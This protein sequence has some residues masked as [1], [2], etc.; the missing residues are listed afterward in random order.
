MNKWMK[1]TA[2]AVIGVLVLSGGVWL[3]GSETILDGVLTR[4]FWYMVGGIWLIL[5]GAKIIGVFH[6]TG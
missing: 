2:K 4:D 5:S 3:I 1:I 6:V